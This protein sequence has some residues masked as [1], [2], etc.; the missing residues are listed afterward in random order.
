MRLD[1]QQAKQ[2]FQWAV[3]HAGRMLD[4]AGGEMAPTLRVECEDFT[5]GQMMTVCALV[6]CRYDD[7]CA[8]IERLAQ[9]FNDRRKIPHTAALITS[10][11]ISIS[12][13][14]EPPQLDPRDDPL[15][16]RA[17]VIQFRT[18]NGFAYSGYWPAIKKDG[19]L[20]RDGKFTEC[21]EWVYQGGD[22]LQMFYKKFRKE[23]GL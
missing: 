18:L 17:V 13:T 11:H 5:T 10:G 4:D 12:H 3:D 9:V 14:G 19:K 21:K 16:S 2:C 22:V 1:E 6:L 8:A 7:R 23:A 20:T 15:A